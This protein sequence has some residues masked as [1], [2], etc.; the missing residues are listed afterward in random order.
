MLRHVAHRFYIVPVRVEHKRRVVVFSVMWAQP[1]RTIVHSTTCEGSLV[2]CVHRSAVFC[3]EGDMKLPVEAALA[4][5]PKDRFAVQPEA[6]ASCFRVS[7]RPSL[8]QVCNVPPPFASTIRSGRPSASKFVVSLTS[9]MTMSV[10]ER[11]S[12]LGMRR[13][14]GAHA[15]HVSRLVMTEAA[16][17]GVAGGVAG[18]ATGVAALLGITIVRRWTPVLDLT[19]IPL[20]IAGGVLVGVLGGIAASVRARRV[21]PSDALRT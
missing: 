16:L 12:E 19:H 15:H 21:H 3:Y 18:A 1:R 5:D 8:S 14:I 4:T 6:G 7:R 13:A 11:S 9:A 2:E 10:L 17:V 20:A